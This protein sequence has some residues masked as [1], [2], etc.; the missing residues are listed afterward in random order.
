[1]VIIKYES[2][3]KLTNE[4][5]ISN[6]VFLLVASNP[7]GFSSRMTSRENMAAALAGKTEEHHPQAGMR[8]SAFINRY[9]ERMHSNVQ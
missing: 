5:L 2:I 8:C 4:K 7:K 1:M 9:C 6:E 3:Q